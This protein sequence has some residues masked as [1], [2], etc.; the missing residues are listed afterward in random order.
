MSLIEIW[1]SPPML[2][3]GWC[4]GLIVTCFVAGL[5]IG[6]GLGRDWG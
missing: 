4:I 6:F 3:T 2:S 5:G 1:H